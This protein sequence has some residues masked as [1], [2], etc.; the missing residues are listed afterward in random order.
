LE[1]TVGSNTDKKKVARTQRTLLNLC[2][3]PRMCQEIIIVPSAHHT[4]VC[5]HLT[6]PH[7][8]PA[9]G[10]SLPSAAAEAKGFPEHHPIVLRHNAKPSPTII[11]ALPTIGQNLSI[12]TIPTAT[13]PRLVMNLYCARILSSSPPCP[14]G[15]LSARAIRPFTHLD[16]ESEAQNLR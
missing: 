16:N 15:A 1:I 8:T 12:S 6:P 4:E 2:T 14:R 11:N 5:Q 10:W 3:Y 7:I 13:L 9:F